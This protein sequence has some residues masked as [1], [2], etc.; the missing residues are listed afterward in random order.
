M[1]FSAEILDSYDFEL[2]FLDLGL[3]IGEFGPRLWNLDCGPWEMEEHR[4]VRL[5]EGGGGGQGRANS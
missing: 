2:G 1:K 5:S 3:Q 4:A